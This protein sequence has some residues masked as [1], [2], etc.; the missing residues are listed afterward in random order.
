MHRGP[1]HEAV[2]LQLQLGTAHGPRPKHPARAR[3]HLCAVPCRAVLGSR[4]ASPRLASCPRALALSRRSRTSAH[5]PS[6]SAPPVLPFL[7]PSPGKAAI[8]ASFP[9][10]S[11]PFLSF[12][13]LLLS[14]LLSSSIFSISPVPSSRP[15]KA[16]RP[17]DSHFP[18]VLSPSPLSC[19]PT[20]PSAPVPVPVPS[21]HPVSHVFPW[22][23]D[24]RPSS[25]RP[26]RW[27]GFQPSWPYSAYSA[28]SVYSAG[29]RYRKWTACLAFSLFQTLHDCAPTRPSTHCTLYSLYCMRI[30]GSHQHHLEL[31][32]LGYRITASYIHV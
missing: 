27:P 5:S 7:P 28:Y 22:L 31:L 4:L 9:F 32:K 17:P 25:L 30:T 6:P 16:A 1:S 14:F 26:Y 24:V 19:A 3:V 12:P 11:F 18:P 8:N 23:T 20:P 29:D 2:Q 13:L 15:Q 21:V 10:L